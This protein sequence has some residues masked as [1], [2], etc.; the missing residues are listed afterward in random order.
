MEGSNEA[1]GVSIAAG[2]NVRIARV[3]RSLILLTL[4]LAACR[5]DA[6]TPI[7]LYSPHG[8]DLLTLVEK[9]YESKHSDVDVRWLDMGSQDVYDRVRAEKANPGADVWYGG[10][11]LVFANGARRTPRAV[12]PTWAASSAVSRTEKALLR[13]YRRRLSR[14]QQAPIPVR[15]RR[16]LDDPSPEL[17][18]KI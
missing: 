18:K 12:R 11:N 2:T 3:W 5:R 17:E 6:R 8:R 16:G 15:K 10:P 1:A 7:V 13:L 4:T 14:L 9:T